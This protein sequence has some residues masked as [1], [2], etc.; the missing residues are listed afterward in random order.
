MFMQL[1]TATVPLQEVKFVGIG[2]TL[3]IDESN[4]RLIA[5]GLHT[6]PNGSTIHTV[7][8]VPL[9]GENNEPSCGPF[10]LISS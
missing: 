2:Q 5:S 6:E 1:C 4:D 7:L 9:A 10:S 3:D 8:E